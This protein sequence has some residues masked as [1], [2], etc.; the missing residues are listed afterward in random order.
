MGF[1]LSHLIKLRIVKIPGQKEFKDIL[2]KNLFYSVL[3]IHNYT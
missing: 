1:D 3:N 2:D